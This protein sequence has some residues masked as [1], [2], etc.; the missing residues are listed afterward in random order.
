MSDTLIPRPYGVVGMIG[1]MIRDGEI[2]LLEESVGL[3]RSD[4]T[5]PRPIRRDVYE[6]AVKL[7]AA[8]RP[9][10]I[11][12]EQEEVK[13]P[14]NKIL[15]EGNIWLNDDSGNVKVRLVQIMSME[16]TYVMET[17]HGHDALGAEI[18]LP[19]ETLKRLT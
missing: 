15:W 14:D 1:E 4:D 8:G 9:T 12:A 19:V 17:F 3:I 18:W 16:K 7:A 11:L 13:M 5:D 6:I 2:T 10:L